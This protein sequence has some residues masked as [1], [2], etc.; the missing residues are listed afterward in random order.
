MLTSF[1][2]PDFSLSDNDEEAAF[3]LFHTLD[4]HDSVLSLDVSVVDSNLSDGASSV[5]AVL[6]GVPSARLSHLKSVATRSKSGTTA[7]HSKSGTTAT[8][9]KSGTT[10]TRSK[11]GTVATRSK[12]GTVAA[13]SKLEVFEDD[14]SSGEESADTHPSSGIKSG[15]AAHS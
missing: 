14:S 13:R 9:S 15:T 10:A 7:T 3:P 1:L 8:R 12:S 6:K 4:F 5:D 11:S 2:F